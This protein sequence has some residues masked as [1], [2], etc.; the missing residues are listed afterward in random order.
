M[1]GFSDTKWKSGGVTIGADDD[2]RWFCLKQTS[3]VLPGSAQKRLF[4]SSRM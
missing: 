3:T 2:P 1:P 4:C